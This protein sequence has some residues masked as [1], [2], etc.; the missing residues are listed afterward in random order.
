MTTNRLAKS[1]GGGVELQLTAADFASIARENG[2]GKKARAWQAVA[3][4]RGEER[5][6]DHIRVSFDTNKRKIYV[7]RRAA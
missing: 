5:I 4:A 6:S 7:P 3:D 1:D 2:D